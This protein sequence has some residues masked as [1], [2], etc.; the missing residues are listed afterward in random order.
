MGQ[1]DRQKRFVQRLA[2]YFIISPLGPRAAFVTYA[3]T[4][5]TVVDFTGYSSI[6]DFTLRIDNAPLLGGTRRI[7]QAL[8]HAANMFRQTGRVGMRI[9]IL[10]TSGNYHTGPGS[11]SLSSAL[12]PLRTLGAYLYLIGIGP[13][14]SPSIFKQMVS[15]PSDIFQVP[16]FNMLGSWTPPIARQL[17]LSTNTCK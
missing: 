16:S 11:R 10:L 5:H 8:A 17:R 2:Q 13:Y 14:F 9:V 15:G 12:L 1:F 3:R 7:D 6:A 4:S